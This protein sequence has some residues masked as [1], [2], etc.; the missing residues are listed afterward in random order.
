MKTYDNADKW[1]QE[2]R[3]VID[4][5]N[6]FTENAA[7]SRSYHDR[8]LPEFLKEIIVAHGWDRVRQVLAATV[9]HAPWNGRYDHTVK[10]WA[11]RVEPFPQ[12]SGH[13]GEPRDFYE[14]CLNTH[15]VIVN[16]TARLL[17]KLTGLQALYFHY[18]YKMGILPRQRASNKRTHFLLR[19]DIRYLDQLTA[20]TKLLCTH[21]IE[22]KEQLLTYRYGLEQEM[23]SLAAARKSLYNRI[24]RCKDD[25]QIA[26]YKQ[27]IS[28]LS[29][30]LSLLRKEVKLCSG[31]LSRSEEMK[32]MK[33]RRRNKTSRWSWK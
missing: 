22:N 6:A 29:K 3:A 1:R 30:K 18:L 32:I 4:C 14:F 21:R 10:E 19:E 17:R 15:P 28:E 9:N 13:Q 31:I 26:A 7:L 25:G 33:R 5:K 20:Q 23:E 2:F 8:K 11:A 16:D 24:G 12:F 27:Q